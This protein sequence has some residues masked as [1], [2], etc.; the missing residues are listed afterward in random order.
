[1]LLCS[2]YTLI[3]VSYT[4]LDV[5]KRQSLDR[6]K[7]EWESNNTNELQ[8]RGGV[9]TMSVVRY[10]LVQ[11]EM[12]VSNESRRGPLS[13]T[14]NQVH[15]TFPFQSVSLV[16]LHILHKFKTLDVSQH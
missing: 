11:V 8:T 9:D 15:F 2:S 3:P 4:H 1:M 10:R 6:L 14:E 13:W 5:Y 16:N 12:C 7:R